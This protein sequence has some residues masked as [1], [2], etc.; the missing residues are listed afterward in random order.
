MA[1]VFDIL[2]NRGVSKLHS[3]SP[4]ITV[5]EAV[6]VMGENNIGSVLV[7]DEAGNMAGIFTERD[8]A[9]KIVLKGRRSR[10]TYVHEIMTPAEKLITVTKDTS[11]EECMQKMT[12][13]KIRHLPVI[14]EGKAFT[15]ISIGDVV[16]SII[17]EQQ[18]T[19]DA[20]ASYIRGG[21]M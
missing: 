1:K 3:V 6:K 21:S 12:G 20:M 19:I 4:D 9:R 10:D 8:Y 16:S 11:I 2:K 14:E 18:F 5:Y 15:V 7:V 17:Q 13:N